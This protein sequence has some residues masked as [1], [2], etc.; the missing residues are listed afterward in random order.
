ML[1][2]G[3]G[4]VE[5]EGGRVGTLEIDVVDVAGL[6]MG[7][8][9]AHLGEDIKLLGEAVAAVAA[10][11]NF[12]EFGMENQ[13]CGGLQV[14]FKDFDRGLAEEGVDVGPMGTGAIGKADDGEGGEVGGGF[15]VVVA[16]VG[17]PSALGIDEA[18][19]IGAGFTGGDDGVAGEGDRHGLAFLDF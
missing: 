8:Q 7:G 4:G 9:G 3:G 13:I 2:A 10:E 14:N 19:A 1:V 12:T 16:V 6:D 18:H 5:L 17:H 11:V 15:K